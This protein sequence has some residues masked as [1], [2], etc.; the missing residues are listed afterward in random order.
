VYYGKARKIR[1]PYMW[2]QV[3]FHRVK[4]YFQIFPEDKARISF[5]KGEDENP[6][7][8][9]I[10][11]FMD[12]EDVC[13]PER[14]AD[15]I[16]CENLSVFCQNASDEIHLRIAAAGEVLLYETGNTCGEIVSNAF[17]YE[18]MEGYL[19]GDEI[20]QDA[21]AAGAG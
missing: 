1:E 14:A 6:S 10:S 17:V 5:W 11:T 18:D 16:I 7:S 9:V 3:D 13:D 20:E 4:D 8:V 19:D 2:V 21:Y 12:A 15:E